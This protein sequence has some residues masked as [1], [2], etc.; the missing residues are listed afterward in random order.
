[1][2][3]NI[4]SKSFIKYAHLTKYSVKLLCIVLYIPYPPDTASIICSNIQHS[5]CIK[6]RYI[7]FD[8][9]ISTTYPKTLEVYNVYVCTIHNRTYRQD[10]KKNTIITTN[11]T[12]PSQPSS[13]LPLYY[14]IY[15][16]CTN[17]IKAF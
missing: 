14:Y 16:H 9:Y 13:S 2:Q 8:R 11:T 4:E 17:F 7:H 15:L 10:E 3:N 6:S 12:H 5:V 1:M